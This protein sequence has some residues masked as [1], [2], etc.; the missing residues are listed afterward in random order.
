MTIQ[1]R[2]VPDPHRWAWHLIDRRDGSEFETGF[3]F[4]SPSAARWAGFSRLAEL[5]SSVPGATTDVAELLSI[6]A[7]RLRAA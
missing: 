4:D 5:R 6:S 7:S 2:L 1:Q 3:E